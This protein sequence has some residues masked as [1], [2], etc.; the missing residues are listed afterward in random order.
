MNIGS[1]TAKQ[2]LAR[3]KKKYAATGINVRSKLDY[4]R[5]AWQD[6]YVDPSQPLNEPDAHTIRS[7]DQVALPDGSRA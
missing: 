2:Y 5:I 3:V 7:V 4:G 1:E 6:G